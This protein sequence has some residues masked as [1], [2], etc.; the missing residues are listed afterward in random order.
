MNVTAAFFRRVAFLLIGGAVVFFF[1]R[2]LLLL[3]A[4]II[5]VI[6]ALVAWE[7]LKVSNAARSFRRAY[8]SRGKD[9]VLIYS[10]SPHWHSYV[11]ANWIPRWSARAVTLNWSERATWDRSRPEVALFDALATAREFN[12]LAIVVLPHGPPRVVRFWRAFRDH[13]HGRHAKLRNQESELER[14][15]SLHGPPAS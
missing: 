13:K 9:L 2:S 10:N 11:E 14:L 8:Q 3:L 4:L 1:W 5:L 12:P 7:R 15:L 6:A